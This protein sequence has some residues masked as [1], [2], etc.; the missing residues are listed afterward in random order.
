VLSEGSGGVDERGEVE[1][2]LKPTN[3]SGIGMGRIDNRPLT[4][5]STMARGV[6]Y[7]R[8]RPALRRSNSA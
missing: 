8:R 2:G 1:W 7:F 5:T 6:T 4:T 3:H